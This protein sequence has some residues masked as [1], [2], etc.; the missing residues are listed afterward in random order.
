MNKLKNY[1]TKILPCTDTPINKLLS[2]FTVPSTSSTPA[3]DLKCSDKSSFEPLQQDEIDFHY[4]IPPTLMESTIKEITKNAQPE[5]AVTLTAKVTSGPNVEQKI[6]KDGTQLP[7]IKYILSDS[8]GCIEANSWG[9][10]CDILKTGTSYKFQYIITKS[11]NNIFYLQVTKR[12]TIVEVSDIGEV[13]SSEAHENKT[14]IGR[15]LTIHSTLTH[16]CSSCKKKVTDICKNL[17]RCPSCKMKQNK[18]ALIANM[19]TILQLKDKET[20]FNVEQTA[21]IQFF[22]NINEKLDILEDSEE[23]E[24]FF[25]ELDKDIELEHTQSNQVLSLKLC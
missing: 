4:K 19:H 1:S 11:F 6:M 18:S 13:Q 14:T 2:S 20:K 7:L 5:Q 25:L 10:Q 12:S 17:V 24:D 23:I 3:Y 16:H 22:T 21:L 9:T 8:T 15:V